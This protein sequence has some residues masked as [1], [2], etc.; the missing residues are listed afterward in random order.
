MTAT[1]APNLQPTLV[2]R[3]LTMRP[4]VPADWQPLFAVAADPEIW[5]AHPAH[6]R[7]QEPVFRQFFEDG[8]ASRGS[9]VAVDN[10]SGAIIGHSRYDLS[11]VEPGE[12]EIGWSFLARDRWGGAANREAKRLLIAHALES[13][14]RVL[15]MVGETNIRSR[16]AMEKIGGILTDRQQVTHLAGHPVLHVIY[17]IDP[18]SFAAGPLATD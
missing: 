4:M 17:R 1:M 10:A 8:L 5:A 14:D 12:I 13:F 3:T 15:F 7:W 11:R 18:V 16:R 2:G 6:D 9:M